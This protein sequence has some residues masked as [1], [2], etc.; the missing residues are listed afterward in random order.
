VGRRAVGVVDPGGWVSVYLFAGRV[1]LGAAGAMKK[2]SD[3]R[4]AGRRASDNSGMTHRRLLCVLALLP[5]WMACPTRTI[6]YDAGSDGEE[7][8]KPGGE[9]GFGTGGSTI[10][11]HA[12]GGAIG[13]RDGGSPT[14][15]SGGS[16]ATGGSGAG[17]SNGSGGSATGGAGGSGGS[18]TSGSGGSIISGAGGTHTGGVAGQ[19]GGAGGHGNAGGAGTGGTSNSGGRSGSSGGSGSGGTQGSGG[20]AGNGGTSGAGG[21]QCGSPGYPCCS[22]G[23]TNCNGICTDL[24]SDDKHCG[25]CTGTNTDCTMSGTLVKQCRASLCR[26]ADGYTCTA[27]SDCFSGK[28]DVFYA[29]GDKDGYPDLRTTARFCTFPGNFGQENGPPTTYIPARSDS[30]WDC[31]DQATAVHPGATQFFDWAGVPTNDVQCSASWGD[32]NCDQTLEVDPAAII[33]TGCTVSGDGS[34]SHMTRTPAPSDCGQDVCGC[35]APSPNS[36]CVLY[37]APGATVGCR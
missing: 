8:G 25:A 26:L 10:G 6:Y 18:A 37:C 11:G 22:A 15:G 29:D 3:V 30:K 9:G 27:D 14:G 33:T 21:M 19:T 17:G 23:Q 16:R 31:C 7:G 13:A 36:S 12:G 28:C 35:G 2:F 32:T 1:V 4:N 34:C 20:V 5:L 24:T